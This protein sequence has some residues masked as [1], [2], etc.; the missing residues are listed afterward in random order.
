MKLNSSDILRLYGKKLFVLEGWEKSP[1]SPDP[2]EVSE[3]KPVLI[4]EE[5]GKQTEIQEKVASPVVPEEKVVEEVLVEKAEKIVTEPQEP[6]PV[7]VLEKVEAPDLSRFSSGKAVVWKMKPSSKLALILPKSEFTNRELTGL[8]KASIV[9]AGIDP[10]FVGFGVMEEG[11]Q[12]I[13]LDDMAVNFALI[14]N[15]LG[16]DLS[17]PVEL[18]EKKLWLVPALAE[19]A[20]QPEKQEELDSAMAAIA[21]LL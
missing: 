9:K 17:S 8:L 13:N 6:E 3:E 15:K 1:T 14:C 10:A 12:A 21:G 18:A 11:S 20:A 4:A 5:V 19:L 7:E 16:G 2:V